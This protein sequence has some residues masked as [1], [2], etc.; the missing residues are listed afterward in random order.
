[1]KSLSDAEPS[2]SQPSE[3]TGAALTHTQDDSYVL[4]SRRKYDA[5]SMDRAIIVVFFK[6]IWLHRVLLAA[7]RIFFSCG[8]RT[9]GCGMWDLVPDQGLNPDPLPW[10]YR[11]LATGPPGEVPQLQF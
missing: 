11:V 10:E 5:E 7:C 4:L 9:L 3:T 6:F 8:M 1:M 2:H